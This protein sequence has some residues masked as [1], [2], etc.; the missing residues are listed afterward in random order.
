M[1]ILIAIIFI[2]SSIQ[3]NAQNTDK[4]KLLIGSWECYHKELEDGETGE[5][6]TLDGQPYSCDDLTISLSSDLT[7]TESGGGL[8]FMYSIKDS[9][10]YLG[11][12]IYVIEQ[13]EKQNLI[14]RDY[15]PDQD[16]LSV[17]RRKFKKVTD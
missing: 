3:L 15:D 12:R 1:R 4:L 16:K 14:L 6:M 5:N 8:E 11:D 2:F 7:G 9:L 13:L 17:F 10:L